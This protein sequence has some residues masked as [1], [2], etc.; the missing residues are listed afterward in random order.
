MFTLPVLTLVASTFV[1]STVWA[2]PVVTPAVPVIVPTGTVS[3]IDVAQCL[4]SLQCCQ[5]TASLP[6]IPASLTS[7]LPLPTDLPIPIPTLGP[8]A[9]FE[10]S[11]ATDLDILGNQWYVVSD[12]LAVIST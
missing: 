10:C 2:S 9:G 4:L 3:D 1:A 5:A 8:L 6:A 7:L 11:S 12:I